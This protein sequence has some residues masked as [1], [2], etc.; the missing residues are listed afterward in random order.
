MFAVWRG[1]LAHHQAETARRQ[2][3]T[4]EQGLL[5]ERYQT[6]AEM[7]G[8]SVLAVRMGGIYALQRLAEEHPEQY[9]IQVLR[10]LCLFVRFPTKDQTPEFGQ[11][12]I[13][14]EQRLGIRQDVD[15]TMQAICSRTNR[16][17]ALEQ[18]SEF[19]IDLRGADLHDTQLLDTNLSRAMLHHA[20]LSN[21]N[22]ANTDLTDAD[23]SYANLSQTEFHNVNCTGT[24]FRSTD[25]SGAMLQDT[26]LPRTDFHSAN[27]MGTNLFKSNLSGAN[28]Q[29][30]NAA[31][32]CFERARLSKASFLATD[33]SRAAIAGADLSG[34]NF[35]AA[36]L[37]QSNLLD[38]DLSG[39]EFSAAGRRTAKGLTQA[40]LDQ[41]RPEAD[42]PP[43]LDG[44]L[45]AETGVPLVWR[46][47]PVN[48]D[49]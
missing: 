37:T 40:Q 27:L 7:L 23:L 49:P 32:T 26:N 8:S 6:G 14:P 9:H 11:A 5:N 38:A 20:N 25:L 46:G 35:S 48:G 19:R 17:V 18:E 36:N 30:A 22:F 42:R 3:E 21:V 45:D 12:T 33:L 15:A 28:F 1:V 10:L 4:A 31:N 43:R 16:G 44:V 13:E 34:A 29:Y 47:Q 39:A 2:S 24:R 41:A